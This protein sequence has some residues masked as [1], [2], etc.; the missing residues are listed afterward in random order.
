M[1]FKSWHSHTIVCKLKIIQL[2]FI[3]Q[4]GKEK[5]SSKKFQN[6]IESMISIKIYFILYKI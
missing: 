4:L 6:D 3:P 1:N 5:L 2:E